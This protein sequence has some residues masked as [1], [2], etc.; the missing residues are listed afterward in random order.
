MRFSVIEVRDG[1]WL[2]L[3]LAR[4][5]KVVASCFDPEAA[6]TFAALMNGDA[7]GAMLR[8]EAAIGSLR[9]PEDS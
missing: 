3:D 2:V 7:E 9:R 6:E 8:R 4:D 1:P 5:R